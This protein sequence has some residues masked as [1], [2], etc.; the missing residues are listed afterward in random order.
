MPFGDPAELL[1]PSLADVLL[2]QLPDL[3]IQLLHLVG[4]PGHLV[5]VLRLSGLLDQIGHLA[6]QGHPVASMCLGELAGPAFGLHSLLQ[7]RVSLRADLLFHLWQ[8]LDALR[9]GYELW[10]GWGDLARF[11]KAGRHH[12]LQHLPVNTAVRGGGL[13]P[14]LDSTSHATTDTGDQAHSEAE[15]RLLSTTVNKAGHTTGNALVVDHLGCGLL[16]G[17]LGHLFQGFSCSDLNR[18]VG[19]SLQPLAGHFLCCPVEQG[20][21]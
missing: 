19:R 12:A 5:H 16:P 10:A 8:S 4:E 11:W 7:S 14:G 17:P 18:A 13:P 1:H 21:V 20:V 15:I 9:L 2:R 6:L 3:S